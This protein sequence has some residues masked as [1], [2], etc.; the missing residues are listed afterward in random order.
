MTKNESFKK[1]RKNDGTSRLIRYGLVG[2]GKSVSTEE[3]WFLEIKLYG[4]NDFTDLELAFPYAALSAVVKSS[5]CKSPEFAT[6][7]GI[8]L[9]IHYIHIFRSSNICIS[10]SVLH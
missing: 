9:C 1:M 3:P 7:E 6:Q 8:V 2:L 4:R 5:P 10:R